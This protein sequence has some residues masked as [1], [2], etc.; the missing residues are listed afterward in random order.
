LRLLK[1]NVDESQEIAARY[2]V[3][4]IPAL[5]LFQKGQ[6]VA[7]QAGAQTTDAIIRWARGHVPAP[8]PASGV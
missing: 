5:L 1:L 4:G 8:S 7:Q 3:S 6:V 2:G